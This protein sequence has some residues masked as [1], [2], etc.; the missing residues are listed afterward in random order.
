[1]LGFIR[2]ET[3]NSMS[4]YPE[5]GTV[6][7]GSKEVVELTRL[8]KCEEGVAR[9]S[10]HKSPR[11]PLHSMLVAQLAGR[12]WRPK[13]HLTKYKSFHIVEGVMLVILFDNEGKI[14]VSE[15]LSFDDRRSVFVPAG[16]FHTNLAVSAV[17]VH[18]EVIEG[19]FK[20]GESDREAAWFAPPEGD[21]SA[22]RDYVSKL[23]A[24]R[25]LH[26][27]RSELTDS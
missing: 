7:F 6:S 18:H 17:A 12:Y 23:L 15:T 9:V 27:G 25:G 10:L 8:A 21:T 3:A 1:M 5:Q 22:S 11:D 4:F 13:R 26:S 19:P 14:L 20:H 24:T 2:D 16:T